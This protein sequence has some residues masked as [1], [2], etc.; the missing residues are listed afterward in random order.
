DGYKENL[1]KSRLSTSGR[2]GTSSTRDSYRY[3]LR[4][5][6]LRLSLDGLI[7]EWRSALFARKPKRCALPAFGSAQA[8]FLVQEIIARHWH[9]ALPLGH[10]DLEHHGRMVAEV[11]FRGGKVEFPHAH[12]TRIVNPLHFFL[13]DKEALT[14][15]LQ[16]LGIVQAQDFNIGHQKAGALDMR[17]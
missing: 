15:G 2:G 9:D 3:P 13:V 14:P 17:K 5:A 7:C 8:A 10:L 1:K 4:C 11:H 6:V 12:E 16:R